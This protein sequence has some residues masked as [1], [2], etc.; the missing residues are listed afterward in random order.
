MNEPEPNDP[1]DALL[2]DQA[3]YVDDHGFTRRV[4][5]ALP[6]RRSSALRPAIVLGATA[7]ACALTVWGFPTGDILALA[8]LDFSAITDTSVS[9]VAAAL[10]AIGSI[11]WRAVTALESKG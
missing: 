5:A 10:I 7:L 8:R 11:V 3:T 4:L 9:A 1:L 2:R 6:R